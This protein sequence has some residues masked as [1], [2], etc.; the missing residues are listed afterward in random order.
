MSEMNL[1]EE[2]SEHD[3]RL[4]LVGRFFVNRPVRFKEMK[5]RMSEVWRPV[6]GGGGEGS[7][8]RAILVPIF[9]QTRYG[10]GTEG[11]SVD[12]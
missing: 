6:K 2:S 7:A 1:E 10:G 11:R 9:S 4:C 3:P 8:T 5:I 12:I